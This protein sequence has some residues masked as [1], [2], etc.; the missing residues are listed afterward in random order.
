ML[1]DVQFSDATESTIVSYF[2]GP[3]DPQVF[4]NQGQVDTSDS[5]WKTF[6]DSLP[7][8]VQQYL[9]TPD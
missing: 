8:Y 4:P 3:Q 1:L 9:P 2:A 6:F 5:R 7:A